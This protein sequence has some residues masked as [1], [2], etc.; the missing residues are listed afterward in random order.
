MLTVNFRRVC[1]I[2]NPKGPKAIRFRRKIYRPDRA[3]RKQVWLFTHI[4]LFGGRRKEVD[5]KHL[6]RKSMCLICYVTSIQLT[7]HL[8]QS[9]VLYQEKHVLFPRK[10]SDGAAALHNSGSI[11][12][13]GTRKRSKSLAQP[14]VNSIPAFIPPLP[15]GHVQPSFEPGSLLAR[16][17]TTTDAS[18]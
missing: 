11:S 15:I 13:S 5:G 2:A 10:E 8:L 3:V 17:T 12:R 18:R 6:A 16:R 4:L 7:P 1:R 14:H 9:Y